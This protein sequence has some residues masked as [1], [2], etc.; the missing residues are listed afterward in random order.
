MKIGIILTSDERSK[1]YI[2]KLENNNIKLDYYFLM[3]DNK[4][5]IF[6]KNETEISQKNGFDI[7]K[8]VKESLMENNVE[9]IEFN[10]VD[11]NHSE[12]INHIK[13]I[14]CDYLIFTGGGILREKIL[15]L[16]TKFIH[17]HPG[18][19]PHYRGSTCFYYSIINEGNTGVTA[20]IMDKTLD[21]GDI[22]YQKKFEKPN[23]KFIDN[24]YDPYIR[25]ETLIHILTEDI[26]QKNQFIKQ[27]P[28]E[29]ET[30]HIIHPV[31][32]HLAILNCI[33]RND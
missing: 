21:T 20:Y 17:L 7:T 18:L 1:A 16:N 31:L 28:L 26:I 5:K 12:L 8:S 14:H 9:F 10:F 19:V 33:K 32:K 30:Y 29:G 2:Q 23:H 13:K 4:E 27:N 25:S 3:N 6:S 22:I 24:V 15:D 11:I